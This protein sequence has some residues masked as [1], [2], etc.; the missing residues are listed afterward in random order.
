MIFV[1]DS[2]N[3][4]TYIGMMGVPSVAATGG[5]GG[6]YLTTDGG[7]YLTADGGHYLT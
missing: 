1:L 5:G 3:P 7:Y 4:Q 6:A 2:N